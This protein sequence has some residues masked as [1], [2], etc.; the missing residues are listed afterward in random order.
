MNHPFEQ[1][2]SVRGDIEIRVIEAATGELVRRMEIRNML[3]TSGM[4]TIGQLLAGYGDNDDTKHLG[5]IYVGTGSAAPAVTDTIATITNPPVGGG[6]LVECPV[7]ATVSTAGSSVEVKNTAT[8]LTSQANG[9]TI[10]EAGLVS[11]NSTD[12]A[13]L[14]FARQVFSGVPKTIALTIVFDWR[15][16]FT[17]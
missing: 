1:R 13:P 16:T 8:L 12:A 14:L 4:A 10:T 15:I 2:L 9:N 11:L 7:T 17:A 3:M 5:R 6:V